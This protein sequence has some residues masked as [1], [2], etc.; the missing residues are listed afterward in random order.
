VQVQVDVVGRE[1][2]PGLIQPLKLVPKGEK[3]NSVRF[4]IV[5]YCIIL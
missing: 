1:E 2:V 5:P 3:A 4:E